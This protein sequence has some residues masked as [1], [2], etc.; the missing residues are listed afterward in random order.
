MEEKAR[1]LVVD[2]SAINLATVE[3][4]LKDSYEVVP[5]NSGSRAIRYLKDNKIDLILLDI[6][7]AEKDGIETLKEIRALDNG[8]QIPVIMLTSKG[9]K[10]SIVESQ[11][12]G[13][14]DYVLKPFDTQDLHNRIRRALEK[15]QEKSEENAEEKAEENTEEVPDSDPSDAGQIQDGNLGLGD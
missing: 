8:T 13:I 2:D 4:K 1:I 6:R 3:Q 10:G 5:M 9:D 12:L 15:A 14:Y 11:R 7:M